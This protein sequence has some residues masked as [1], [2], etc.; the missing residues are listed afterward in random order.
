MT[1]ISL[2]IIAACLALGLS[3]AAVAQSAAPTGLTVPTGPDLSR[4]MA[5]QAGSGVCLAGGARH[6]SHRGLWHRGDDHHG[7]VGRDRDDDRRPDRS[8]DRN[9]G[10]CSTPG[11]DCD[12]RSGGGQA[13]RAPAPGTPPANGL[14][15]NGAAPRAR[16]N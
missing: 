15:D 1:R 9:Q 12:R 16:T 13:M 2:P 11:F 10:R 4:P 14:F 5:R 3:G 7:R 6:E 8:Q